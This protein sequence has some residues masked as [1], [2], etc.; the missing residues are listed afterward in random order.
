MSPMMNRRAALGGLAA[1][2]MSQWRHTICA[3]A[4]VVKLEPIKLSE[5]VYGFKGVHELMVP[6]NEGAICNIGVIIG[7]ASVA[8]VDS[9]GSLVEARKLLDAIKTLAERPVKYLINTHMHPDHIFGNAAFRDLGVEIVGHHNLPAALE[10]RGETY[11]RNFRRDLG[12]ELMKGV[13]IVPPSKLVDET[14]ELD[15]GGRSLQL[16]AWKTAHTDNDLTVLDTQSRIL[17]CGDLAFIGHLPTIDGSI[18]GWMKQMDELA[19]IDAGSALIGHGPVPTSWPDA[20]AP[21]RKYFDTLMTDLRKSIAK[22]EM[23]SEAVKTAAQSEAGNW[24]LFD[25][26]NERNASVA[27][28]ELEWE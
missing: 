3:R 18:L 7:D 24:A 6:E 27:F 5:G 26:Y 23:M 12:E 11:L 28:A 1:V 2:S 19:A 25:E 10:A 14:L 16:R 13:E 21:Q 17:F 9:G 15:L 4:A 22:G 20:L 8:V